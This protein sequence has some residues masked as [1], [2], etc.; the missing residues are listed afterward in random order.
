[1]TFLQA[2][3]PHLCLSLSR[4]GSSSVSRIFGVCCEIFWLMLKHMRVMMKVGGSWSQCLYFL[5]LSNFRAERA[6]GFH[7]GNLSGHSREAKRTG[8]S[9]AVFH[10]GTRETSG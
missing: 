2:V 1:M 3:R 8:L 9:E 5:Y 10:G 7:E 4:N 6:R